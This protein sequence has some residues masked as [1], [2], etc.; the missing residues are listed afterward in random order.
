MDYDAIFAEYYPL[1]RG[2]ATVPASTDREYLLG[3][4][5][6]NNAIR[7]WDRADGKLW[8]ELFTTAQLQGNDGGATLTFD[9]SATST[10]GPTNM[11]KP[12]SFIKLTHPTNTANNIRI[13]VVEASDTYAKGTNSTYAY[14]IGSA[15]RQDWTLQF[16]GQYSNYDGWTIDYV[17]YR[18]PTFITEG[19]GEV[20]DMSDPNF[21][22][23]SMLQSRFVNSRNGFAYNDAKEQATNALMNM[24]IE[25]DSGAFGRGWNLLETDTTPGFGSRNR[26]SFFGGS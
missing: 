2:Q 11:R 1:Y 17:Y 8:E 5:L 7:R 6:A 24:V 12:G 25:N 9:A 4:P 21:I 16:N 10:T 22:I 14:F 20:V 23:Q 13:P 26:G 15:S 19:G 18:T 3:I